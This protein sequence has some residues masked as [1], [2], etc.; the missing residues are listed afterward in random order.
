MLMIPT[1]TITQIYHE[2]ECNHQLIIS[3]TISAT[4]SM[5]TTMNMTITEN[6]TISVAISI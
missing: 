2:S 1:L 4:M 6:I 5:S 3:F